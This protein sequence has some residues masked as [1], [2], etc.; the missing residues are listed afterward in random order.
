MD[1]AGGQRGVRVQVYLGHIDPDWIRVELY[2][3]EAVGSQR[4]IIAMERTEAIV[5]ALNGWTY[6]A[7]VEAN[8][9]ADDYTP[10]VVP[11]H[12]EVSTPLEARQILWFR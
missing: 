11:Y 10:R 9:P 8:R 4:Q 3:D 1:E 5:G 12:P 2:A 6:Q 7:A